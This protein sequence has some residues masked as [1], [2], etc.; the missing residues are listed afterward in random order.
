MT[1][2]ITRT[3]LKQSLQ[4]EDWDTIIGIFN[5]YPFSSLKNSI[6]Y[7]LSILFLSTTSFY[8]LLFSRNMKEEIKEDA[9]RKYLLEQIEYAEYCWVALGNTFHNN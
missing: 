1:K 8:L 4:K 2:Q 5:Q 7:N 9:V 3:E 6:R